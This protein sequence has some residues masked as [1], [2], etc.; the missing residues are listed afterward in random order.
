M[1]VYNSLNP[2]GIYTDTDETGCPPDE[3]ESV[4]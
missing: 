1:N 4:H 2:I 3:K